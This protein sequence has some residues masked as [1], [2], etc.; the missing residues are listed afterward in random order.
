M[1]NIRQTMPRNIRVSAVQTVVSSY[2]AKYD[3]IWNKKLNDHNYPISQKK[4][5]IQNIVL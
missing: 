2:K 1:F 3:V 5:E 4:D